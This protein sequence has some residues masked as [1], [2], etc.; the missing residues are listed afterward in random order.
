MGA[1]VDDRGVLEV[2]GFFGAVVDVAAD[3]E[4]GVESEDGVADG[5]AANAFAA[6][7][8]IDGSLRR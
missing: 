4:A 7:G 5:G 8:E 6:G 1:G 2:G 3:D